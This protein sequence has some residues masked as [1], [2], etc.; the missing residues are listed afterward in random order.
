MNLKRQDYIK[1]KK[2]CTDFSCNCSILSV[3]S[4]PDKTYTSTV[5]FIHCY[6][7]PSSRVLIAWPPLMTPMG[8]YLFIT[9]P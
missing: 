2:I 5:L 9:K 1:L 3:C 4:F 7:P 8:Q 6:L